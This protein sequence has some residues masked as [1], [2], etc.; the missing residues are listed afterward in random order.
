MVKP[1][2]YYWKALNSK[3][4]KK[5]PKIPENVLLS[6]KWGVEWCFNIA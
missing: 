1:L 6:S 2:H 5:D 3:L 4:G